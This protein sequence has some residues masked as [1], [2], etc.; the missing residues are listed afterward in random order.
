MV[1]RVNYSGDNILVRSYSNDKRDRASIGQ[2]VFSAKACKADRE[3]Y[4]K[5]FEGFCG[6]TLEE[7]ARSVGL[8]RYTVSMEDR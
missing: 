2:T 4:H 1:F 8:Q 5:S 3:G 6:R 7:Y